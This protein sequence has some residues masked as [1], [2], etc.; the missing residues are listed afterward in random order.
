MNILHILHE[1]PLPPTSGIRC[2]MA[3]RAE[4]FRALGH[5]VFVVC[6][7]SVA[8]GEMPSAHQ[9]ASLDAL[10]NDVE[11]LPIGGDWASRLRRVWNLR[12][13]PSYVAGRIPDRATYHTL[14]E[15]ITAFKPDV[16][17]LEGVHP[18]WL[19]VETSRRFKIPLAYRAHNV[20]YRYVAEQARLARSLRLKFALTAG[21]WGLESIERR[22]HA[23]ASR[24]FDISADDLAYWQGEGFSNGTWLAPQPDSAVLAT[25]D[26]P[27]AERDIDI[28]FLGSL[29]SPNNVVGLRWYFNSVHPSVIAAIPDLR[30][31]IA[32][33][34]P[35]QQLSEFISD[36]GAELICDP[37][38]IAPLFARALVFFNPILHGSGVNIKTIDMLASGR[39]VVTTSKG[40]RGL[41]SEVIAQLAVA[42]APNTFADRVIAAVLA[43]R[44]GCGVQDRR[45][46]FEQVFGFRAVAAALASIEQEI[47]A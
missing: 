3:R 42:D 46:L 7:A 8:A 25:T 47:A 19:A 33:R 4:A 17:W 22:L 41:P 28:L 37:P 30:L 12:S 26:T 39:P 16:V 35:S 11:V 38:E 43:A 18:M 36:A 6:W 32:G 27:D 13:Y 2:D 14:L 31:V 24:V 5:R 9:R 34:K 10:V 29:S 1:F 45:E 15:R 23:S 21:T 20:E 40:A 44:A